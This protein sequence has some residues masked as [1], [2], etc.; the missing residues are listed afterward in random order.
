MA[1]KNS[2]SCGIL[3]H[4]VCH[5]S[6]ARCG[7]IIIWSSYAL[8]TEDLFILIGMHCQCVHFHA[9]APLSSCLNNTKLSCIKL[10]MILMEA[11]DALVEFLSVTV[12]WLVG[13]KK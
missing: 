5:Y 11:D 7:L 10:A 6:R 4:Y 13:Q 12:N 8:S 9:L 3:L 2:Q 1:L